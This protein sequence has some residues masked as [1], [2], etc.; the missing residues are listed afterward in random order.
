MVIMIV[1][2][3]FFD[4][5][6]DISEFI[7]RHRLV[8]VDMVCEEGTSEGFSGLAFLVPLGWICVVFEDFIAGLLLDLRR[9]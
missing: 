1:V 6:D 4:A 3:V 5:L 9:L 8:Q 7:T 2:V